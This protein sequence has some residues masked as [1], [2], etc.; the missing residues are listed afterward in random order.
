M[1]SNIYTLHLSACDYYYN[2]KRAA[3]TAVFRIAVR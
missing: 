2:S 3:Y 1:K